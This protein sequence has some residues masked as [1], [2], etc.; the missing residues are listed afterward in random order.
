MLFVRIDGTILVSPDFKGVYLVLGITHGIDDIHNGR[1]VKNDANIPDFF[2]YVGCKCL[3]CRS[4]FISTHGTFMGKRVTTTLL[5]WRD[6]I[7]YDGI[8]RVERA[9]TDNERRRSISAYKSSMNN[10]TLVTRLEKVIHQVGGP[11]AVPSS[12]TSFRC[13]PG[14]M[15]SLPGGEEEPVRVLSTPIPSSP[16]HLPPPRPPVTQAKPVATPVFAQSTQLPP[17]IQSRIGDV[18]KSH[19]RRALNLSDTESIQISVGTSIAGPLGGSILLG[20]GSIL[21]GG[22]VFSGGGTG[23]ASAQDRAFMEECMSRMNSMD[24]QEAVCAVC[25]ERDQQGTAEEQRVVERACA[26][27]CATLIQEE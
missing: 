13:A 21:S 18:I 23:G 1:L 7:V 11:S 3:Q 27:L 9:M 16:A 5:N 12:S 4:P 19:M 22:A 26:E 10:G 8:F 2:G 15:T 14:K 25:G 24:T 20:G 6:K 17:Q